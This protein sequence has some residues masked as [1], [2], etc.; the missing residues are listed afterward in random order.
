LTN[1]KAKTFSAARWTTIS[2]IFRAGLQFV[3]VAI[4]A[5]VLAPSDFGLMALVTATLAFA[6][7]FAD[8]GISSAIIHRRDV[9]QQ[10]LSS[11]FWLNVSASSVLMLLLMLLSPLFAY[12]YGEPR[13]TELLLWAS[14][15]FLINGLGQQLRVNA[16]KAL[17]FRKLATIEIIA[18]LLGFAVAVGSALLGIG[19]YALIW[20]SLI[21]ALMTTVLSWFILANGWRPTFRLKLTEIRTFLKFGA[22]M[23]GNNVAN[24]INSMLDIFLGGHLLGASALGLYSLPRNLALQIAGLINPIITRIGFPV[25]AAVQH[26]PEKIKSIYL[27]TMRMTASINFPIYFGLAVFSPSIVQVMFGEQWAASSDTLRILAFWGL[28]RSTGNP[29]GSLLLAVGKADLQFRWNLILLFFIPPALWFGAGYGI[30]GLAF[31]LLAMQAIL[32]IPAW[33]FLVKP[34]CQVSLGE[35]V[36]QIAVPFFVC[37]LSFLFS[38]TLSN[39]IHNPIFNLLIGM[40]SAGILYVAVS[41]FVNKP[42]IVA[43]MGLVAVKMKI[44]TA[45]E[46]GVR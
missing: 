5:R 8:M 32:F 35:Y 43:M 26:E 41:F 4:L 39:Q 34:C 12:F 22:Y 44:S 1:L 19:V 33:Y 23:I 3:Q 46:N 28:I 20:G 6:T 38:F 10:Q 25:M 24:T 2:S 42:W 45:D 29:V 9:T 13:L 21:N 14:C 31:S 36:K 27:K 37:I 16:E 15:L 11:L 18:A 17:E 40:M 30:N 7:I